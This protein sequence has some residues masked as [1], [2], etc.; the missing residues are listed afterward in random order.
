MLLCKF[1]KLGF[2]ELELAKIKQKHKPAFYDN[3]GELI[4]VTILR[5]RSL[6]TVGCEADNLHGRKIQTAQH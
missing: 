4:K 3:S 1:S 5:V 2:K 6:S